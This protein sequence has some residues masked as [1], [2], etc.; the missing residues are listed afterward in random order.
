MTV[1]G[2]FIAGEAAATTNATPNINP[3]DTRDVIGEFAQ[4]S[5]DDV[6]RASEAAREAFV[7]W[8]RTTPQQRADILF[9]V[10]DELFR[11]REELGEQLAREEGKTRAEG[12]GEVSR[13]AFVFRFF[14]GEVVRLGGERLPSVRPSID[15]EITRHPVGVIGLITPW[16][17]PIAIVAWKMAPA[18]A[19]GNVTRE[20]DI[21][22]GSA[23]AWS[24]VDIVQRAG[25]TPGAVNLVMGEGRIVGEAVIEGVDAVSFTGSVKTGRSIVQSAARRMIPVQAEMGGKNPLVV[26]D[27]ADLDTAVLCA[28]DG[29]FFQ[30]GQRCTA[31]SRLIVTDGIHDRFV[32]ALAQRLEA[33][34]IG[35]ALNPDT[36]VGPAV[37]ERQLEQDLR[38]A[39]IGVQEGARKRVAGARLNRDTPGFYISPTLFV[40]TANE[41]RINREEIF[42]PVASVIRVKD[43]D[44]ALATANDTEFG[45]SAGIVTTSHKYARDFQHNSESGLS[46]VNLATAGLDYH[47]P[48]GGRKSSS[49]GPREQGTYA[50]DF[51]TVVKTTY[52][53]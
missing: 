53:G 42:G 1:H 20:G 41:M 46:M 40:D 49:Y 15:V 47:V 39:D 45:L 52:V 25:V 32:E 38:Y 9:T 50:A 26:L 43:Y 29:S 28:L 51:Y 19:F 33:L 36:Q 30:T 22:S 4:A 5:A 6:A 31:S 11:R 17:F 13:A 7:K 3:S 12:I 24:L 10:S 37:S 35:H 21:A 2:N 18:L 34:R 44:E 48:F 8:S 27:D 16:N 23:S 14:A